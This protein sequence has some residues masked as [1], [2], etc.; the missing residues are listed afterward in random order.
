MRHRPSYTKEQAIADLRMAGMH[1][2]RDYK[3]SSVEG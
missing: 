2:G 1:I 3:A